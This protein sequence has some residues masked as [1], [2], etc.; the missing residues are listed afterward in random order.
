MSA[1]FLSIQK[2]RSEIVLFPKGEWCLWTLGKHYQTLQSI[3]LEDR[4]I[5]KVIIDLSEIFKIDTGGAVLLLSLKKR[6]EDQKYSVKFEN[7]SDETLQILNLVHHYPLNLED[8]PKK[9]S[10]FR[11]F[12]LRL[13]EATVN[14]FSLT[15][16]LTSFF[17]EVIV[18]LLQSL[19]KR[20]S[21]RL[22]SFCSHLQD[23]GVNALPI[24]GLISFLIG[25]VLAYQG[26]TQLK[27]F[28]TEIFTVN[29]LALGILR[30]VGIL[31]TAIVVAG[32]SGS[33]FTAQIGTMVLNEEVDAMQTMGL[34]PV[35]VLVIPRIMAL[36]IALP[37]LTF[38]SDIVG[39]LGGAFMTHTL[40]DLSYVQFIEQLKL[41]ITPTTFW[42]GMVKSPF[43]AFLIGLVG[44]FEGLQVSGSA[45][46]IGQHT[47]KSVVESIFL[48]IVADAAFSILFSYLG[49]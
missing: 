47:T 42:V 29:L 1:P 30:E 16:Q 43:F 33:A 48:V 38:F 36:M 49:I 40:M 28:G 18:T 13:G 31:I 17:G 25:V 2:H 8:T 22:I 19:R 3:D 21:F 6:L 35:N 44:C 46:S 32:R 34:D 26:V 12:V 39:L 24:V 45:E 37:L 10:A 11:S 41:A 5:R 9:S 15:L 23:V 20:S 7:G 27:R 4:K 14:L